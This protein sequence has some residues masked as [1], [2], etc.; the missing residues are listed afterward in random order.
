MDVYVHI[1]F[2]SNAFLSSYESRDLGSDL[3]SEVELNVGL[4][5][6]MDPVGEEEG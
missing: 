5:S 4:I 6:G 3:Q 2:K 1:N